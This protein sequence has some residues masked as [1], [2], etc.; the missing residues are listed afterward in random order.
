L[1]EYYNANN[2]SE[3]DLV[4]V[5]TCSGAIIRDSGDSNATACDNAVQSTTAKGFRLPTSIEWEYAARYRGNDSANTVSGYTNPYYTQGNSASGA[6]ADYNNASATSAVAVYG[7]TSTAAVKS[8]GAA[9]ANALGLCDMS[10]NA[11]EWCFDWYPDFSGSKRVLRGGGFSFFVIN[12]QLGFVNRSYPYDEYSG[13][14][15]R[16]S[17]NL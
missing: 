14:G 3:T 7:A 2:G 6:T 13:V 16:F 10:G 11:W 17:R 4:C 15:F 12:M 5:Y 8:K 9:G 1:T